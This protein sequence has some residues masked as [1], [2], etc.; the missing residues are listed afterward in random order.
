MEERFLSLFRLEDEERFLVVQKTL[1]FFDEVDLFPARFGPLVDDER[2]LFDASGYSADD[3]AR[4]I[5][6]KLRE[7]EKLF[8][9][10]ISHLPAASPKFTGLSVELGRDYLDLWGRSQF[11]TRRRFYRSAKDLVMITAYS[12]DDVWKAIGYEGPLLV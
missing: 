3:F 7:D 8:R 12:R 11:G 1:L 4:R 10:F 6:A 5:E 9:A 2:R